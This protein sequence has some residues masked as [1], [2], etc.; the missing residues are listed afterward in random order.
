MKH[1]DTTLRAPRSQCEFGDSVSAIV[2]LC[3]SGDLELFHLSQSQPHSATPTLN[4]TS[5]PVK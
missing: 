1:K 5:P 3:L 2:L 4:K